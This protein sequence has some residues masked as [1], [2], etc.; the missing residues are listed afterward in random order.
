VMVDGKSLGRTTPLKVIDLAPGDHRIRIEHPGYAPWES[1]LHTTTGTVLPLPTVTL[2]PM[3]AEPA[4]AADARSG[5]SWSWRKSSGTGSARSERTDPEPAVSATTDEPP[6]PPAAVVEAVK[7]SEPPP[8]DDIEPSP[9]RTREEPSEPPPSAAAEPEADKPSKP[10]K[11][12]AVETGKLRVNT[13]PW[14]QVFVD[15]KSYGA[16]P[17]M[18]IDLPAGTHTL[19]LI[20]QEFNITKTLEVEIVP[21]KPASVVLDLLE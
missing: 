9:Y 8:R 20:N 19:K 16:T 5:R 10:E 11:P 7:P 2:Q 21:G 1:S 4:A 12:A 17:R 18:N 3:A 6:P 14:S 15:G 13:R